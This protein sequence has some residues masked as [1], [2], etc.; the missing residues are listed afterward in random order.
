MKLYMLPIVAL[1]LLCS[2]GS[3]A[4][5]DGAVTVCIENTSGEVISFPLLEQPKIVFKGTYV[6]V[7]ASENKVMKFKD[8]K[9]VY[10]SDEETAV[11]DAA[12][13]PEEIS[14]QLSTIAFSNFAPGTVARVYTTAGMIVKRGYADADGKLKIQ[15]ADLCRGT[16]IV[17]AGKT[18]FKFTKN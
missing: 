5:V 17:K 14:A 2:L 1:M 3:K 7:Q 10:F 18:T 16:Y 15:T 11:I 6:L 12:A 13:T 9:S 4:A 8:L